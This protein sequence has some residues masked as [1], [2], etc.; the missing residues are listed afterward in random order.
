MGVNSRDIIEAACSHAMTT[1]YFARVNQY[2]PKSN[3]GT[4]LS[5]AVWVQSLGAALAQSGLNST[6]AY[7]VLNVRIYTSMLAEPQDMIDP[8]IMEAVDKL[9]AAYSGDFTLDGLVRN[10]DLLGS[11]AGQGLGGQAGYLS[12]DNQINRVFT[13][14]LPLI[15]NDAWTQEP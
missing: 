7:F 2:E 6:S 15:V 13:I 5:C 14:I 4:G 8:T 3:P 11:Q 9:M 12:I 1:G 10:V